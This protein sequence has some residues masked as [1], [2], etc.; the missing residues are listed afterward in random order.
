MDR[1]Y[2]NNAMMMGMIPE[3]YTVINFLKSLLIV[4][5]NNVLETRHCSQSQAKRYY[6]D[7]SLEKLC[8]ITKFL[9][10]IFVCH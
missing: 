7:I 9:R 2:V 8:K 1:T 10:I 3:E 5:K 6:S 4:V